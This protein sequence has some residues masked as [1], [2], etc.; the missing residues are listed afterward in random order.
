MPVET[1]LYD[2]LGVKPDASTSEIKK[3]FHKLALVH[4]PDKGGD[5]DK[6]KRING[7]YEILRDEKEREIYDKYGPDGLKNDGHVPEDLFHNLFANN[8]F[9]HIFN[10]FKGMHNAYIQTRPVVYNRTVTLE[11][12]CTRKVISIKVT[13]DRLCECQK[14]SKPEQCNECKGNGSISH[15]KQLGP[16]A[17]QQ[18]RV[19]CTKCNG[20]GK[21][22]K[23]CDKCKNGVV[24]KSKVFS[25]HLT[26]DT[27]TGYQFKFEGEGNHAPGSTAGDFIVSVS[28]KPHEQFG[29]NGKNLIYE[30]QITLKEALC[31]Y[32][33]EVAHPSGENILIELPFVV[34][35]KDV[36]MKGRGMNTESDLIVRHRISIPTDLTDEQRDK[37]RDI[38]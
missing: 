13:R 31:G 21:I 17:F 26:P 24:Q 37:L 5:P 30:R 27:L 4:H 3:A 36:I 16:N 22:I 6:F 18:L 28:V 25:I 20:L 32:S 29:V 11:E 35:G 7:A 9:G 8:G 14:D 12:L 19:Q 33:V 2:L 34:P 38:L 1:K 23:S 15:L 10:V